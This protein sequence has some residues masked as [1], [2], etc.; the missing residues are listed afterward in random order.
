MRRP[1]V[2]LALL[3]GVTAASAQQASTAGNDL[4]ASTVVYRSTTV[5]GATLLSTGFTTSGGRIVAV[6]P[7]LHGEGLVA[8][9]SGGLPKTVTV[10]FGNDLPV[11]CTMTSSTLLNA[12]TGVGEAAYDCAGFRERS[13]RPRALTITAS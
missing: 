9:L 10:R 7:K 6:Q 4:P 2:A 11:V 1:L 13:D 8:T 12:V 3:V 5:T